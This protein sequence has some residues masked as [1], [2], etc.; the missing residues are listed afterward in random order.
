M[1]IHMKDVGILR[2]VTV[3]IEP[4]LT[5]LL[6]PSG[7][8]KSTLLRGLQAC[9]DNTLTD[10]NIR[11]GCTACSIVVTHGGH[12]VEYARDTANRT[13]K[14]TYVVDGTVYEKVGRA[15]V[16]EVA[17]ALQ[18]QPYDI[19]D[20]AVCFN[21]AEQFA[22]PF[23]LMERKS[24]L[25]AVL[26]F[27][28]VFD[29]AQVTE[30]YNADVRAAAREQ[31]ECQAAVQVVQD[32]LQSAQQR[33]EQLAAVPA[34]YDTVTALVRTGQDLEAA[35]AAVQNLRAAQ[36][37]QQAVQNT[38]TTLA[39]VLDTGAQL[40][41]LLVVEELQV[42]QAQALDRRTQC[43]AA[44]AASAAAVDTAQQL[45]AIHQL[46]QAADLRAAALVHLQHLQTAVAAVEQATNLATAAAAVQTV[47]SV[48]REHRNT[49]QTLGKVQNALQAV[50][51]A[52]QLYQHR[53]QLQ[54][55]ATLQQAQQQSL[56]LVQLWLAARDT[57]LAVLALGAV[58][59]YQRA[60]QQCTESCTQASAAVAAV[61]QQC[62][63][64]Q[65][66]PLCK[67]ALPGA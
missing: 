51:T 36:L 7:S 3:Q 66:C 43:L 39:T 24:L 11:T 2:D 13:S 25:Y 10:A 65:H 28:D 12:T 35:M 47:V 22:R 38:T 26:T 18:L 9:I 8:G 58:S 52:L 53:Q 59:V 40:R 31:A 32:Q 19:D 67:Q 41:A 4:G 45:Q 48:E 60:W 55:V 50:A 23:L 21:F 62:Q 30:L 6:G 34:L 44:R 57:G 17:A 42:A 56:G 27:R 14:A 1:Q 29:A 63:Q 49:V 15:A 61:A 33:L 54:A 37:Q 64:V 20:T 5:L 16:P 46:C